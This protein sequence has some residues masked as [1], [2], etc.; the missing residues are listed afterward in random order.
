MSLLLAMTVAVVLCLAIEA[1]AG[2]GPGRRPA[3]LAIRLAAYALIV[4]FWFAFS[5]RPWL[6][7]S[8]GVLTV[9]VLHLVSRLKRAV[10]GEALVFSDFA[11]LPQVPRHP[12][13]YY[14]PPVTSPRVAGP[15]L[16]GLAGVA[17]WYRAEPSLLPDAA[18]GRLAAILALPLG[19]F[20]VV[21]AAARPP[22][23]RWLAGRFPNPDLDAD[24]ARVGL[25]ACLTVH[26]LRWRAERAVPVPVPVPAEAAAR[27]GPAGDAVVVVIQLESFVDPERLGGPHLPLMDLIRARAAEYGR[28]RVP[29]HGAYTMRTE[30]AVLT[31]R[32][33]DDL[34]FGVFDPYL[35]SGGHEPGSLARLARGHGY[36]TTFVHPFHR[37][38]FQRATVMEALGFQQLVMEADFSGAA[39]AGPYVSDAAFG[40]R[41][42]AEVEARGGPLFVFGVTMENHGPWKP[43]RLPGIDDPLAQ[44]LHHVAGT[45]R[46]VEALVAGLE[47]R[48]ATLC[49]FGDHAPALPNCRPGFGGTTTDYAIFRFG[50]HADA[51]PR[52]VDR[53]AHDLGRRLRGALAADE[54]IAISPS[55]TL[56]S[57]ALSSVA[58]PRS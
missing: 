52:R 17:L 12:Q 57:V 50:R 6:A 7:A 48:D 8:S 28:L 10:V 3:D 39:R 5:W 49:V 45:G 31:G 15:F 38:F 43:G 27:P 35:A 51:P 24:I 40:A 33:P 41:I 4:L 22:L 21:L 19:L 29:A 16:L 34:G 9:A 53:T 11:L 2:D 14:V 30:H 1:T 58:V 37:D 54:A 55:V 47:G 42:L 44:Y 46:M 23:A 20:A 32:S 26:T 56:S 18:A 36:A 13:L 25:P